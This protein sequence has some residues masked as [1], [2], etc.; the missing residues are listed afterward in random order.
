MRA[1]PLNGLAGYPLSLKKIGQV[2][3]GPGPRG[4]LR[5]WRAVVLCTQPLRWLLSIAALCAWGAQA[6]AAGLAAAWTLPIVADLRAMLDAMDQAGLASGDVDAQRQPH[7]ATLLTGCEQRLT[8]L[9]AQVQRMIND[10]RELLATVEQ[11]KTSAGRLRSLSDDVGESRGSVRGCIIIVDVS[12]DEP[13]GNRLV[14]LM[15]DS[16]AAVRSVE[17]RS[18]EPVPGLGLGMR[19]DF[20]S[21][22][23]RDG[24]H[25]L[26]LL[27]TRRALS[28][29]ELAHRGGG[30]RTAPGVG[31]A[32][33]R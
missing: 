3:G 11:L 6:S 20:L 22:L 30:A 4:R 27:D 9:A 15:V 17:A 32:V 1:F 18:I 33:A 14:A 24:D 19:V 28:M 25:F 13:A 16:V 8:P 31:A 21:G 26:R 10:K 29:E 2:A 23:V 7:A 12:F 5:A